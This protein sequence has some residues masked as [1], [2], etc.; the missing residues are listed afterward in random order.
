MRGPYDVHAF[1]RFTICAGDR[2]YR[3]HVH[4]SAG[5]HFRAVLRRVVPVTDAMLQEP[6]PGDWLMWRRTLDS[7]GYSPLDE[8]NQRQRG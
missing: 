3:H 5:N 2:D 1:S 7:W 6:A 4:I 8:I